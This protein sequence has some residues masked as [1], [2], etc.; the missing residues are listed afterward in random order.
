MW[1][2]KGQ[3]DRDPSVSWSQK[4]QMCP[5]PA[6]FQV[7]AWLREAESLLSQCGELGLEPGWPQVLGR[8]WRKTGDAVA[9]GVGTAKSVTSRV[10]PR[11]PPGPAVTRRP[12]LQRA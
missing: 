9:G 10:T 2:R 3:E 5:P 6:T 12:H 4:H 1:V 11:Q 8:G 7:S